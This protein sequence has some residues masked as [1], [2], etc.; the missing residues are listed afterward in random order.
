MT[1]IP[2][3]SPKILIVTCTMQMSTT[4]VLSHKIHLS[5][6]PLPSEAVDLIPGVCAHI[7]T[8]SEALVVALVLRRWSVIGVARLVTRRNAVGLSMDTV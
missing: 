2:L 8:L 6:G 7:T 4:V 1:G 3:A 5:V